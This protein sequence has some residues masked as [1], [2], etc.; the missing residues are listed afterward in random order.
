MR[1]HQH[2]RATERPK[3][4]LVAVQLPH[5]TDEEHEADLAELG[6]LVHTLGYDVMASVSQRRDAPAHSAFLGEGKL[7]ELA[8][9]T[10]GSGD[11]K[12]VPRKKSKLDERKEREA[13]AKSRDDEGDEDDE[14]HDGNREADGDRRGPYGR[15]ALIAV[16]DEITP[17]Q[18]RNLERATGTDVLD[19]PGVIIEIFHRHARSRQARAEVE[20][21]RLKYVAPRMREAGVGKG[22]RQAGKGAGES[23]MELDRRK[24]RDRIA[25]LRQE[26]E[27][28]EKEAGT[29]RAARLTE[30]R[31]ALVGYTNAGKSSLM[32]ALTGSEVLVEDKL[33]AT[34]DTTVRALS[35]EVRPR[36]LVSDTVGFIQKLPHDLVASFKSTLDEA[37]LASLLL[38]VVDASDPNYR[39]QLE[40]TRDTLADIGASDVPSLLVLNKI[41]RV[42]EAGRKALARA[43][44]DALQVSAI[45]PA[46]VRAVR[47]AILR[48]FD[49]RSEEAVLAIPYAHQRLVGE[50]RE[51]ARVVSEDWSEAGV[52]LTVRGDRDALARLEKRLAAAVAGETAG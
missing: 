44:P 51:A 28:I 4:I 11:P 31:V 18:L 34:L 52:V 40:V 5:V 22:E 12:P 9:L 37:L 2:T 3:A 27:R 13:R 8:A 15:I 19:R 1:E 45:D 35:P 49:E 47:E 6:R 36:V 7:E 16:D 42:D 23:A 48:F 30:R 50:V 39:R 32:R 46:G 20:I 43:H 21:A 29:R 14:D 17:S 10:G 41:D 33:F 26:I 38:Y 24:V 25:E